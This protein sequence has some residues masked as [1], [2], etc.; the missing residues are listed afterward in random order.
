MAG[1]IGH[2]QYADS[3]GRGAPGTGDDRPRRRSSSASTAVGYDG[4]VGLEFV[5]AGP[6]APALAAVPRPGAAA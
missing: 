4:P 1:L 5:P 6:T 2:V 3:P